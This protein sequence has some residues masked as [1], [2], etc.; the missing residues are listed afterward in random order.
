M[1]GGSERDIEAAGGRFLEEEGKEGHREPREVKQSAL[2]EEEEKGRI[3][4]VEGHDPTDL[5]AWMP[6]GYI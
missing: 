3:N 4:I 6:D 5:K 2:E 1:S